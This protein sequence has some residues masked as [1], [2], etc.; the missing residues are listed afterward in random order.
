MKEKLKFR[1]PVEEVAILK[2]VA[3]IAEVSVEKVCNVLMAFGILR[4]K[5]AGILPTKKKR[6]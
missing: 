6:K 3:K 4:A 2:E 5:T 1:L